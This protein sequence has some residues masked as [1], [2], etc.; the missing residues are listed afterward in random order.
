MAMAMRSTRMTTTSKKGKGAASR[1][2]RVKQ[3]AAGQARSRPR[4][5]R[6]QQGAA[7]Q[8]RSRPRSRRPQQWSSRRHWSPH[9]PRHREQLPPRRAL[10]S[11]TRCRRCCPRRPHLCLLRTHRLRAPSWRNWRASSPRQSPRT[12]RSRRRHLRRRSHQSPRA[13]PTKQNPR[14]PRPRR[15]RLRCR[16]H[17]S[18]RVGPRRL[19]WPPRQRLWLERKCR[20]R[21]W[22]PRP[23]GARRRREWWARG[24]LP[25]LRLRREAGAAGAAGRQ[26]RQPPR[27]SPSHLGISHCRTRHHAPTSR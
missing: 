11:P 12:R 4:S 6:L 10:R 17:Q 20:Y 22:R 1:A 5:R 8:A 18:P 23:P 16:S 21:Q 7:G 27:G 24:R 15:R 14:T 13:T 19:R 9:V 2:R 26:A 3:G 25:R